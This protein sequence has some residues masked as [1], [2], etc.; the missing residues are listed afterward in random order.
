M[1]DAATVFLWGCSFLQYALCFVHCDLYKEV[2]MVFGTLFSKG[3]IKEPFRIREIFLERPGLQ[4]LILL[5]YMCSRTDPSHF[6][7]K[8]F[9][10][11]GASALPYYLR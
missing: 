3:Q 4:E 9:L 11:L 5:I 10:W 7:N 1:H 8:C 6:K 2:F